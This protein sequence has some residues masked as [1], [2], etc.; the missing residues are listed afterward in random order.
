MTREKSIKIRL[1]EYE[2]EQLRK[3][4]ERQGT[5]MSDVLRKCI[6]KFADPQT[7]KLS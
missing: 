7:K 1:S 6:A 2:Y 4:A 3:E 5:G